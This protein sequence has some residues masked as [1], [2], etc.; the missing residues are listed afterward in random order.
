MSEL[1]SV[2]PTESAQPDLALL[3]QTVAELK[4]QLN[5]QA[6]EI[7]ALQ[8]QVNKPDETVPTQSQLESAGGPDIS[9][10][11]RK[12]IKRWG[13]AAAG[14][15]AG[16]GALAATTS[17]AQAANG[18]NLVLGTNNNA[19]SQTYL[20]RQSNQV[21]AYYR[22]SLWV[23]NNVGGVTNISYTNAGNYTPTWGTSLAAHD[24]NESGVIGATTGDNAGVFGYADGSSAWGTGVVG[25]SASRQGAGVIGLAPNGFNGVYG[26]SR[27][28]TDGHGILG[29]GVVGESII[30]TGVLGA[31]RN[32]VAGV[33]GRADRYDVPGEEPL[34]EIKSYGGA[35][36]SPFAPLFLSSASIAGA[37][38]TTN[39]KQGEFYVDSNGVLWYCKASGSATTSGTWVN[40]S[41]S[42]QFYPFSQPDRFF[43]SRANSGASLNSLQVYDLYLAQAGSVNSQN[44]IPANARAVTG[45]LTLIPSSTATDG[46]TVKVFPSNV[47]VIASTGVGA[48]STALT[49]GPS[50]IVTAPVFLPLPN[51]YTSGSGFGFRVWSATSG[52]HIIIDLFG[53]YL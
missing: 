16:A 4:S 42:A 38:T 14:L 34:P 51:G 11:R 53:Y 19:T 37:P 8:Q 39:H 17:T 30:G 29:T 45:T 32:G 26:Y 25:Y 6:S 21:P 15:V 27:G 46:A 49:I 10:T 18:S 28:S 2:Q 12:F 52:F 5:Q 43:D 33:M 50:K 7:V 22:A 23:D 47:T 40:L 44:I 20:G 35:F 41:S 24:P 1:N 9:D 3:L 13:A 48:V 36:S 31:T